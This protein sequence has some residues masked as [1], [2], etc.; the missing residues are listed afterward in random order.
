MKKLAAL[1]ALAVVATPA[2]ARDVY[3]RGYVRS[4]GTYVAPHMQTAPD[5]SV[6][7]NWST[8]PN[9]NPYTGREGTRNPVPN[10]YVYHAPRTVMP[11]YPTYQTHPTYP[12]YRPT[13]PNYQTYGSSYG[14]DST[15][16]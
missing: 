6:Y 15:G 4:D 1:T 14:N 8:R 5:S 12:N 3:V 10:P 9:V 2:M 13:Y 11:T 7:N 16:N